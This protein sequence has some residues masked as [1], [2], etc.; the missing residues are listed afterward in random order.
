MSGSPIA[1]YALL[2]AGTLRAR[3]PRR[4]VDWLCIPPLRTAARCSP[5]C[6][7]TTPVTGRIPRD[8]ATKVSPVGYLD[9]TM[10]LETTSTHHR[11]LTIVDAIAWAR[12]IAA[13][14]ATAPHPSACAQ[15][16]RALG[17]G[18][19]R[20]RLR[21]PTG[22]RVDLP[23]ADG[24]RRRRWPAVGGA[25]I[26]VLSCRPARQSPTPAHGADEPARGQQ[27]RLRTH[28]GTRAARGVARGWSQAEISQRP[29]GHHLG[30]GVVSELH[31]R[32]R[33]RGAIWSTRAVA[34][35]R[36]S[37]SSQPERSA[38]LATTSLPETVRQPQLGLPVL[39]GPR[40]QLHDRGTVGRACPDEVEEFFE[41][42]TTSAAASIGRGNDLQIMFGIGG[43]HDL[44]EGELPH[45]PAVAKVRPYGVGNG[46]WNQRQLRC[47][48]P[49]SSTPSTACRPIHRPRSA[50][51]E[52]L[53][54][55]GRHRCANAGTS[56]TRG[57]GGAGRTGATS[58]T[59]SSC[60][61]S[62]SSGQ[63]RSP[64]G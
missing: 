23:A 1:D 35:S 21:T 37:R 8:G 43:E 10:V 28:H 62:R 61:G 52:V 29:R 58:C 33:D 64:I 51:E 20:G 48:R 57:L 44:T 17:R 56:A 22:V 19:G 5:G 27:S 18:R 31:R 60:A 34:C 42:M 9:R 59:R 2:S 54:R 53:R 15:G 46:A 49:S 13:R 30:V 40:C 3:E 4:S 6:W 41:Y 11:C 24:G 25:D 16:R 63:S 47:V 32:R 38:R 26:L 36:R 7:A 45:L 55:T 50:D 12:A 14:L 39:V